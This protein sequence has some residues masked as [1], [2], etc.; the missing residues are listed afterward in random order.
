MEDS[1]NQKKVV[2][3]SVSTFVQTANLPVAVGFVVA[4]ARF[5]S[6][7]YLLSASPKAVVALSEAVIGH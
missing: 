4:G 2:E 3:G 7:N 1:S 5:V 6:V